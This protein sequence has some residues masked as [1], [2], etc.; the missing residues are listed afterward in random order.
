[1]Q[2]NTPATLIVKI[3]STRCITTVINDICGNV[4]KVTV[5]R[6]YGLKS[7]SGASAIERCERQDT[8]YYITRSFTLL[9]RLISLIPTSS[10]LLSPVIIARIQSE[11]LPYVATRHAIEQLAPQ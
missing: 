6:N 11:F 7:V 4:T 10:F 1:M 9:G 8:F 2:Q 5:S 3:E